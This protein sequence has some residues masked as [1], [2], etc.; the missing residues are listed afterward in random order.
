MPRRYAIYYA[1]ERNSTLDM[2][3][4]QWL[5]RCA[6]TGATLDPPCLP[7][8]TADDLSRLTRSPRHYGFHGTI[9][10]PF[11]LK[12]GISGHDVVEHAETFAGTQ[13]PFEMDPLAVT[14]IGSFLALTP[15]GQ[16]RLAVLAEASLRA[17]QPLRE[18]P[19]LAEMERRRAKGLTQRQE[20]LLAEWGYPY[21][22]DEYRFHMTLTDSV[23]DKATRRR[24]HKQLTAHATPV[25]RTIQSVRELCVFRQEDRNTPFTLVHRA[26]LGT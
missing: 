19:T 17:F 6:E 25:T 24:L 9:V 1:P 8:F 26:K 10:P 14:E 11:E 4:R 5:G 21:V 12:P 16:D 22:L 7:G 18:Q 3:G 2:F 23:P 13:A 20:R 15:D